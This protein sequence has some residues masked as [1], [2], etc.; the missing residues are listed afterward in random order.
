MCQAP[1]PTENREINKM[2][3]PFLGGF[4]SGSGYAKKKKNLDFSIRTTLDL[5]P[6]VKGGTKE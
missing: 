3:F 4:S 1:E 6:S 2:F 5:Y